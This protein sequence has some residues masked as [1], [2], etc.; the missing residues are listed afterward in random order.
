MTSKSEELKAQKSA[1]NVS[2]YIKMRAIIYQKT[3]KN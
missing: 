1:I 2:S 3:L